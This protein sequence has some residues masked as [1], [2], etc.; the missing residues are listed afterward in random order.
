MVDL[1][2]RAGRRVRCTFG[3]QYRRFKENDEHALSFVL[4][5]AAVKVI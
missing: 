1:R 4:L 3:P 2:A 5:R